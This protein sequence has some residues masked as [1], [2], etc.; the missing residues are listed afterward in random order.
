MCSLP[1][2]FCVP[3]G[4]YKWP[5]THTI[6]WLGIDPSGN[7]RQDIQALVVMVTGE[8]AGGNV[9][10]VYGTQPAVTNLAIAPTYYRPG[11]GALQIT[12]NAATYQNRTVSASARFERLGVPGAIQTVT[13]T[14]QS[15]GALTLSWNGQSS[16]G[17]LVAAGQ[18]LV[19][20]TVTDSAGAQTIQQGLMTINY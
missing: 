8:T 3:A 12:L 11:S 1:G 14:G 19:T 2:N 13:L 6:S 16:T 5:G 10:Q 17:P 7:I 15:P 4:E 20:V 18:Y 9:V